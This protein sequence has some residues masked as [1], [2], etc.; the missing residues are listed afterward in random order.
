MKRRGAVTG[1]FLLRHALAHRRPG[2]AIRDYREVVRFLHQSDLSRRFE[3]A[4]AGGDRSR[5]DKLELR[6]CLANTIIE[7]KAHP[8]FD[9]DPSCANTA[10]ADDLS[11]AQ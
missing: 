1:E 6:R 3:H 4:T 2:S 7:K 11:D 8:F 9:A 5:A 10:I